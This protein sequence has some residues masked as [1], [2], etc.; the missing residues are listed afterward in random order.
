MAGP[1]RV[2]ITETFAQLCIDIDGGRRKY[3]RTMISK[4]TCLL[5]TV[6]VFTLFRVRQITWPA[7]KICV[8]A[9]DI[10][11]DKIDVPTI[12]NPPSR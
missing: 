8:Y 3:K 1:F 10:F 7:S 2:A 12:K 4:I 6:Y 9:R 11:C 5:K